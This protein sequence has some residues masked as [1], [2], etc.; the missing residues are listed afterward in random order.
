MMRFSVSSFRFRLA[1]APGAD[2][3]ASRLDDV[4]EEILDA[5]TWP[6]VCDGDV[7]SLE[8]LFSDA[9]LLRDILYRSFWFWP[10]ARKST[11][12]AASNVLLSIS[13]F[14]ELAEVMLGELRTPA[15]MRKRA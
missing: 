10:W 12:K 14:C 15:A 9:T 1:D 11:E 2:A 13:E 7:S 5:G 6:T 8:S 4:L 3:V